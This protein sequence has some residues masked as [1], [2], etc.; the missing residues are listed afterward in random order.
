MFYQ[1]HSL[2]SVA[3]DWI[4]RYEQHQTSALC[5]LINFVLKCTGCDLQVDVHDIEDPD[6]V[7]SK[8]SDLQD[9]Y[10]AQK[11]TDYPLISKAKGNTSFRATMTGFIHA[12]ISTAHAAGILYS[13]AAL[14][15]NIEVWVTTM[16]SSAVRPFR[17]TATVICLTIASTMCS[18]VHELVD[19][20]AKTMRQREGE[21]K[22]KSVN[23]GRIKDL[24]AKILVGNKNRET[25]EGIIRDIFDTVFVHRYRDVDPKIRVD[26]ATALGHWILTLKDVFF[27]GQ[28][29]RYLG[30]ILS[31]SSAP[32]RAEVLKQLTRLYKSKGD[33][34]R[35]R[36]FTERFRPRLVEMACQDAEP[37]I[38]SATI[39]L[40]DMVR[41][42][43]LIDPEEIDTIGKLVYDAEPRVRKAVAGFFA[44]N[45]NDT[46]DSVLEELGGQESLD[47]ILGEE[48]E[49][50][51]DNPK[52]T[53]LKFKCL[54]EILLQYDAENNG[55]ELDTQTPTNNE[56]LL[57]TSADSRIT[58]AAHTTYEGVQDVRKWEALAGYLLYDHSSRS[59][60]PSDPEAAFKARCQLSESE[61]IVL[62]EVL[63]VAV[64]Q[65]LIEAVESESDKKSKKTK[66]RQ[67]ESRQIQE[68]VAINLAKVIPRLLKKYGASPATASTVLRLVH[69]LNLKIFQELRQ[70]STTYAALLDD[71]NKQFLTHADHNVLTEA[72]AAL[73]HAR[74]FEDL[75]EVTDSKVQDLW[76][77]TVNTLR[78]LAASDEKDG[79]T[80]QALC[81]TTRR[82]SH[83]A[84]ISECV[85]IF[86]SQ[87]RSASKKSKTTASNPLAIL[88]DLIDTF[89]LT[90]DYDEDVAQEADNLVI[91]ATSAVLFYY[92]WQARSLRS[93]IA[94]KSP[95]PTPPNY[96]KFSE[97]LDS[98]LSR[99]RGTDPVRLAAAGTILDLHTLF[100]TFRNLTST[101]DI[102][103]LIHSVPS[104]AQSHIL[105]LF[106][107]LEKSHI[108][109][110]H[111]KVEPAPE[112]DVDLDS[113]P[114]D[115]DS[116]EIDEHKQ[117]ETLLAERRLCELASKTVLAILAKVVD[118][119]LKERLVT[120]KGALGPNFRAVV[121]Y[122]EEPKAKKVKKGKKEV[123]DKSREVV[124]DEEEE[125]D[126]EEQQQREEEE[127]ERELEEETGERSADEEVV[128]DGEGDVDDVIG[129]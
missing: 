108:R 13:D 119:K 67:G 96:T 46:Y 42:A 126:E 56:G 2:D 76:D 118:E 28:Y 93:L 47:E 59:E 11:I 124:V 112:D 111:R 61:E 7:T 5:D 4:T 117:A 38:R 71:I 14:I 90:D 97:T 75:D 10:A 65:Q 70:D 100:A 87:P 127:R 129:D 77:G 3:A 79:P 34:G 63:N 109:R 91:A 62:L 82:I 64:K 122:L 26:C 45:I 48:V 35:L 36:A 15:E 55:D 113:E 20:T 110:S 116:D 92:M 84:S 60:N 107:L 73:L 23:K 33:V 17:H 86:D 50:D 106:V 1:E 9:E 39:E 25:A 88:L 83:L 94:S 68:S 24:E 103:I 51:H 69:D 6:N 53:W 128:L 54:V 8:L 95:I 12:L 19:S 98:I 80:V 72:G 102:S 89:S 114:E 32:T 74:S 49:D 120:N 125:E 57:V 43:G 85:E 40:L 37:G 16:S 58:T 105:S 99:R 123:K 29:L 41:E 22:K 78:A 30:W 66:Q 31:D 81:N 121:T 115:S 44:E 104:E 18:L 27:E 101:P 21:Q 52:L